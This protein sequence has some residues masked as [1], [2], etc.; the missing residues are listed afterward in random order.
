MNLCWFCCHP[1]VR[2]LTPEIVPK[3]D[4]QKVCEAH[5]DYQ[6][7][8]QGTMDP[9]PVPMTPRMVLNVGTS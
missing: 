9:F 5:I 2:N 7:F 8:Y 6:V 1:G 3:I 4:L